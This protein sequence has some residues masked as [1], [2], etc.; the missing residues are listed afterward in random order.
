MNSFFVNPF[1][2]Q[3]FISTLYENPII[4][5]LYTI[6]FSP[7]PRFFSIMLS[8]FSLNPAFRLPNDYMKTSSFDSFESSLNFADSGLI[9]SLSSSR[10]LS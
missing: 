2:E 5:D 6:I 7:S 8:I 3:S 9:L 1:Y 10:N 4:D